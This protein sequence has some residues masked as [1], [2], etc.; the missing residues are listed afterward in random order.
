[1]TGAVFIVVGL[2][3]LAITTGVKTLVLVQ[4]R[5]ATPGKTFYDA[6]L[7]NMA[8]GLLLAM[9]APRFSEIANTVPLFTLVLG[10]C[11]AAALIEGA[12]LRLL[13]DRSLLRCYLVSL[14]ANAASFFVVLAL[15]LNLLLA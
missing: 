10:F 12:V 5:W 14:A 3:F 8:S 4:L 9:L 1:M 15:T 13:R 2:I 6:L 11:L 7:A